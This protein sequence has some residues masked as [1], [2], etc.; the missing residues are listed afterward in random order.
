MSRALG[1]KVPPKPA[2]A[3]PDKWFP[4]DGKPHL[5]QN[6]AGQWRTKLPTP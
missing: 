6:R 5:E 2:P 3:V 1:P 4:V